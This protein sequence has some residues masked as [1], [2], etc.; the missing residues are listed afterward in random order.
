[1]GHMSMP[2]P[3]GQAGYWV[4]ITLQDWLGHLEKIHTA[5]QGREM[6]EKVTQQSEKKRGSDPP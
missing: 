2:L 5:A 3:C 4:P 1:M 6:K